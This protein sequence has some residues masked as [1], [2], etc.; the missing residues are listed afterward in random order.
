MKRAS[1]WRGLIFPDVYVTRFFFKCGLDVQPGNLIDLGC[2]SGSN[3]RLF[4]EYGWNVTGIDIS[5]TSLSDAR[6][7][8]SAEPTDTWDFIEH[9][10]RSGLP[11]VSGAFTALIA[12]ASLYYFERRHLIR[13][14]QDSCA[15]LEPGAHVY[16]KFRTPEDWRFGKGDTVEHNTFV[17]KAT[18][19]GEA[20]ATMAFYD[21]DDLCDILDASCGRLQDRHVFLESHQN[22]QNGAL[23]NNH[24]VI[25]WGRVA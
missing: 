13:V 14:L 12:N 1:E 25:V 19:T 15:V 6:A 9:D 17:L 16:F 10:L 18:E 2:G 11:K 3:A 8:W 24:D 7:N 22:I 4:S 5:Q 21:P 23:I 20:G